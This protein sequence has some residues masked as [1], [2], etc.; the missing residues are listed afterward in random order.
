VIVRP[1]AAWGLPQCLRVS[2]G[3]DEQMG[4]VIAALNDVLA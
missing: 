4:R 3:A 2:V 1:M